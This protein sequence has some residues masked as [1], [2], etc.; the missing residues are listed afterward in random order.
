M[1]IIDKD[2]FQSD[3]ETIAIELMGSAEEVEIVLT[4]NHGTRVASNDLDSD[5]YPYYVER[6]INVLEYMHMVDNTGSTDF[7]DDDYTPTNETLEAV[8]E[9][10][11]S[12]F[13]FSGLTLT[14]EAKSTLTPYFD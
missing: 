10:I 7:E 11:G 2:S 3:V 9:L 14:V 6:Y 5:D 8:S 4:D 12:P 13:D 1:P